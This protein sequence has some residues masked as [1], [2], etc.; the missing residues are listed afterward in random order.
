MGAVQCNS[1]DTG[2]GICCHCREWQSR[3]SGISDASDVD[4][5]P[6]HCATVP[7][8]VF[9]SAGFAM[10]VYKYHGIDDYHGCNFNSWHE[11]HT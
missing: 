7:C 9:F 2:G 1:N 10:V 3:V 5:E 6:N 4:Y 8:L 11:W